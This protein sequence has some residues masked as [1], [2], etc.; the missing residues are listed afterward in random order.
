MG[1]VLCQ[2]ALV[3]FGDLVVAQMDIYRLGAP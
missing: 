3:M 1:S 2:Y